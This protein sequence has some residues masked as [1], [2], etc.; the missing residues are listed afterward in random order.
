MAAAGGASIQV[1]VRTRHFDA[2]HRTA[3]EG[4]PTTRLG[5]VIQFNDGSD[6][7][8]EG[9]QVVIPKEWGQR[10]HEKPF[11]FRYAFWGGNNHAKFRFDP[12]QHTQFDNSTDAELIESMCEDR[13]NINVD[14]ARFYELV[15]HKIR[16]DLL[17]G[18]PVVIF[19]YGLSGSG[20][21]YTTFGID[22]ANLKSSWFF[23][24]SPESPDAAQWGL[25]PRLAWDVFQLKKKEPGYRF[26]MRYLQNVV[27]D[28][29]DLIGGG[30]SDKNSMTPERKPPG[31]YEHTWATEVELESFEELLDVFRNAAPRK[32]VAPTQF[33]PS[34]T[35]GHVVV[36]FK[37]ITPSG[38]EGRFYV[39]DLAG[40]EKAAEV[41]HYTYSFD[42]DGDVLTSFPT[43]GVEGQQQTESLK[44]Q[45]IKINQSLSEMSNIFNKLKKQIS[46]GQKPSIVGESYW[47]NK[48]LKKSLLSSS[49]WLLC[50]IRP[51]LGYSPDPETSSAADVDH[52]Y[53]SFTY[54][55]LKFGQNASAIKTRAVSI[56]NTAAT[57]KVAIAEQATRQALALKKEADTRIAQ[58]EAALL[59]AQLGGGSGGGSAALAAL[60][61]EV[62]DAQR[63]A[64]EHQAEV[65]KAHAAAQLERDLEAKREQ[66]LAAQRI[67][68]QEEEETRTRE[69]YSARGMEYLGFA[70]ASVEAALEVV[71]LID[72][73]QNSFETRR[74]YFSLGDDVLPVVI[75]ARELPG[76][77][78]V[79]IHTIDDPTARLVRPFG[80]N[81]KQRQ[82]RF[83]RTVSAEEL[84]LCTTPG[85]ADVL[86][87]PPT[88]R[89]A[90]S[91]LSMQRLVGCYPTG[92]SLVA[93]DGHTTINGQL[94]E[95][96]SPVPL[97]P[98]DRIAFGDI[99]FLVR[100]PGHLDDPYRVPTLAPS[101]PRP[102]GTDV[103]W[104]HGPAAISDEDMV[105]EAEKGMHSARNLEC[106]SHDEASEG[107]LLRM[108]ATAN[109]LCGL[110]GRPELEF[111]SES[112]ID[113]ITGKL[114]AG[115]VV[116]CPESLLKSEDEDLALLTIEQLADRA[117]DC[118][119][120]EN[121][122][123]VSL[124]RIESF[125]ADDDEEHSAARNAVMVDKDQLETM[126]SEVSRRRAAL[127]KPDAEGNVTRA[128][129][130]HYF[131]AKH[132]AGATDLARSWI[133]HHLRAYIDI[134]VE[135]ERIKKQGERHG[136][137]VRSLLSRGNHSNFF[138]QVEQRMAIRR[139]STSPT[140]KQDDDAEFE[141]PSSRYGKAS[142]HLK[143]STI[144]MIESKRDV[145]MYDIFLDESSFVG[146]FNK[147]KQ[148]YQ[149]VH[150]AIATKKTLRIS[151][152]DDPI[153]SFFSLTTCLGT[154]QCQWDHLTKGLPT[155]P[156]RGRVDFLDF[157]GQKAG[158]A[159]VTWS[160]RSGN[161]SSADE[162][163][164]PSEDEE[165]YMMMLGGESATHVA[166]PTFFHTHAWELALSIN[167]IHGLRNRVQQAWVEYEVAY[168]VIHSVA[169]DSQDGM[170]EATTAPPLVHRKN[171][172]QEPASSDRFIKWLAHVSED[173]VP[174]RLMGALAIPPPN[175]QITVDSE[176]ALKL[177]PFYGDAYQ[178]I[179]WQARCKAMAE[180]LQVA[181][182]NMDVLQVDVE[183]QRRSNATLRMMLVKAKLMGGRSKSGNSALAT[184]LFG[185]ARHGSTATKSSGGAVSAAA[186]SGSLCFYKAAFAW[187]RSIKTRLTAA[188]AKNL[189][190]F[191]VEPEEIIA[192]TEVVHT[193]QSSAR[194][195]RNVTFVKLA[196]GRGWL[197]TTSRKEGRKMLSRVG[198]VGATAGSS[199]NPEVIAAAVKK[200]NEAR[201]ARAELHQREVAAKERSKLLEST[202]SMFKLFDVD[203]E[204]CIKV[205]SFRSRWQELTGRVMNRKERKWLQNLATKK[206][207]LEQ[208]ARMMEAV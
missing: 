152:E 112:M 83:E 76:A 84:S 148:T 69:M 43:P 49:V 197:S 198:G 104:R 79:S 125:W 117:F 140:R 190:K 123:V 75:A 180:E 64:Q 24:D 94:V 81:L 39:C 192:V 115:V 139:N 35:R 135:A 175:R 185:G 170:A 20:K 183:R 194:G 187:P 176:G 9:A 121:E 66:Q 44:K 33:N 191:V 150:E 169:F 201:K 62:S 18:K 42:D 164:A 59:A 38:S 90:K 205:S 70:G 116:R 120:Q 157:R 6:G 87:A 53:E 31:F 34:S 61:I 51:E 98:N 25:F 136:L 137:S 3:A 17:H 88:M 178:R 40:S 58:L 72:I 177:V 193:Q 124:L 144:L 21:T 46:H 161:G 130:N 78:G 186:A 166:D 208:F 101:E 92:I 63:A 149:R 57:S 165:A 97:Y 96:G 73:R 188:F 138:F 86:V 105:Y 91:T 189:T 27:D 204:G 23:Q 153:S 119:D 151:M 143:E 50:A 195:D 37:I 158:E 10:G 60:G 127:P 28:V 128:E 108:L 4:D 154:A 106:G 172:A 199:V 207:T 30:T 65:D 146:A 173:L 52:Q 145:Q 182:S 133:V 93:I 142:H 36:V 103:E 131:E 174:V 29:F 200:V 206:I 89:R 1:A 41:K 118:F 16:D 99:C 67:A 102:I 85:E 155:P 113:P 55:T 110:M 181:R 122:N 68:K 163:V 15:G 22:N 32:Q 107:R 11:A 48:F 196:D 45:G 202:R 100:A 95:E 184:K 126:M 56:T 132:E 19:A 162:K 47:I 160:H 74:S 5:V 109:Q 203:G 156:G 80:V 168:D 2:R 82:C 77:G 129:W 111:V 13:Q 7:N 134:Y 14:Q 8:E 171:H 114:E 147:L 141:S 54:A 71:R 159:S 179:D 12:H 26:K 167:E